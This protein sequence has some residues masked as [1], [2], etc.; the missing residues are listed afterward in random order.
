MLKT[1]VIT[2][3]VL[4]LAL[5]VELLELSYNGFSLVMS[6]IFV[7]AAWEWA[8]MVG[9]ELQWQR[10][11]YAFLCVI[12]MSV[13]FY[14]DVHKETFL[15]RLI[16]FFSVA[17]W[18]LALLAVC[19]YPEQKSW[20]NRWLMALAGCWLLLPVWLGL[21][22]LQP[23]V[24]W[25]GLIWLVIAA[26]AAADIGAY[27]S[28]RR[29]GRRKL[30][31]HVSPGKTWEGFLG[32]VMANLLLAALVA[33]YLKLPALQFMGFVIGMMIVGCF[34]VL[35]D[36]FESMVKRERGIKDSSRLLPGHGGVLD[37]IDGWTAAVPVFTLLFLFFGQ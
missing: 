17:G 11:F 30:A 2:A 34:S 6:L 36:L 23:Q 24:I 16:L 31:L 25:S 15:L 12:L 20:S 27:F 26:V 18:L 35:G 14:L 9:F 10:I 32:G 29:F 37:R 7:V 22:Y 3:C 13:L 21:L 19:R 5:S 4:L 33:F 8:N 28:G 1:R